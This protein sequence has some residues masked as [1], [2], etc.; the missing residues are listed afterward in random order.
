MEYQQ[1]EE[2]INYAEKIVQS[3]QNHLKLDK[4]FIQKHFDL[5]DKKVLDFG[6][7]MGGM[8]LWYAHT[9]N[10]EVRGVDID[11]FHIEVAQR[12][13][14]KYNTSNVSFECRNILEQ[15]LTEKYDFIILNDVVEHIPL[16]LLESILQQL[17]K[18]LQPD[19]LLF[20]SYP[21]WESPY[22][23]HLNHDIKIPWCQFLPKNYLHRLIQKKNRVLV[24][25]KDLMQEYYSLNKLTHKKLTA[26]AQKQQLQAKT[27]YSHSLL[28][29]WPVLK[30]INTDYLP[31]K[32]LITKEFLLLQPAA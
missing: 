9:W 5:N 1:L 15:P 3:N 18:S 12:L 7:G 11:R 26:L 22:A 24:G 17:R 16:N 30:N 31:W 32:Y 29:K 13:R 21:P 20:I 8:T 25:E 4:E 23:S 14:M 19:G 6:C 10:C 27:R 2:G 28:K